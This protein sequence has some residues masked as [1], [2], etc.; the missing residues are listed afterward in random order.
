MCAHS[1]VRRRRTHAYCDTYIHTHTYIHVHTQR[2]DIVCCTCSAAADR[3]LAAFRFP[4]V[5]IDEAT[6][7]TEPECLIPLVQGAEQVRAAPPPPPPPPP[8]PRGGGG[9]GG[10]GGGGGRR[11]GPP[12]P[13]PPPPSRRRGAGIERNGG[14]RWKGRGRHEDTGRRHG[15]A[16]QC[17]C[18]FMYLCVRAG[19]SFVSV[20]STAA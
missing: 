2:A 12:P 16:C 3:R 9:R 10:G 15:A 5:L 14:C 13:P 7:A 18:V 4:I 20:S 6:Q 17:A 11:G 1:R 8:P 19:C